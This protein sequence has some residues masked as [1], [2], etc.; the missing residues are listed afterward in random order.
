MQTTVAQLLLGYI[1]STPQV[2]CCGLHIVRGDFLQKSPLTHFVA[3]PFQI[4]TASLGCGL[5]SFG[6]SHKFC[7]ATH[8]KPIE[9]EP[10]SNR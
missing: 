4:A 1:F 7:I 3:A 2:R 9:S 10:I 8:T 6:G 5:V